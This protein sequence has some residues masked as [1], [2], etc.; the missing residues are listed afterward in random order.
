[1]GISE[2]RVAFSAKLNLLAMV[3]LFFNTLAYILAC[4]ALA[5]SVALGARYIP[6]NFHSFND[7]MVHLILIITL[8]VLL[9]WMMRA[10][11][12]QKGCFATIPEWVVW[13]IVTYFNCLV[14]FKCLS[15]DVDFIYDENPQNTDRAG[16]E[17]MRAAGF[18]TLC[19]G[20]VDAMF[21]A[22]V[23]FAVVAPAP[24]PSFLEDYCREMP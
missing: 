10:Y 8:L 6:T 16:I 12:S 19:V 1:M 13:A 5:M 18:T 17:L 21:A 14:A 4:C 2:L 23:S 9:F 3:A 24:G 15:V 11:I 22:L 20:I 7:F